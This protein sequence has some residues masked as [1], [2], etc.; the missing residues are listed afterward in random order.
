MGKALNRIENYSHY[1]R[2]QKK[3]NNKH[4]KKK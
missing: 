2:A 3:E 4:A 1:T